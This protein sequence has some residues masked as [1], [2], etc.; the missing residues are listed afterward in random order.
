MLR[1]LSPSFF[2]LGLFLEPTVM[3]I[4]GKV[5]ARVQAEPRIADAVS[6]VFVKL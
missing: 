6:S 3:C 1:L 5:V 2:R 4:N